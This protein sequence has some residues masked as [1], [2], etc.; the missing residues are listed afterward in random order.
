[1]GMVGSAQPTPGHPVD[2]STDDLRA[3][4]AYSWACAAPVLRV[5]ELA[6][7]GDDR[8]RRALEAARDF[9]EGQPSS[10]L[11]R[12]AA[13]EAL[14]AAYHAPTPA[15]ALAARAAAT[16][17]WAAFASTPSTSTPS[18]SNASASTTSA[19]AHLPSV[20]K[21]TQIVLILGA[22]AHAARAGE[23]AHESDPVVAEYLLLAA[24]KRVTPAALEVLAHFPRASSGRTRVAALM[25]RLDSL[26]RDPPPTPRPVTDDGPFFH[27]TRAHL[28]PGDLL[29]AGW[30]SNYGSRQIAN[31]L[32]V[33]ASLTGAPLAA[34]LAH[35]DGPARDYRSNPLARSRMTRT[36][37]TNAFPATRLGRTAPAS[38]C[39]SST[40]CVA[41]THPHPS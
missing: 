28:N 31:H 26:L 36:S 30:R 6:R 5:F 27:G 37:P 33:T 35:G 32:Y 13:I 29:T 1:M 25:S 18:M 38:R 41:G 14:R 3:V 8:P 9:A 40:R 15:A 20:V 4:A 7:P 34:E 10:H 11:E 24:A 17:P 39:A 12:S 19:A 21:A 2:L 23:L 16:A 22:A